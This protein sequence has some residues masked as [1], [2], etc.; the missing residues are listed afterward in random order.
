MNVA[1]ILKIIKWYK[2][3]IYFKTIKILCCK[4]V[5]NAWNIPT[6]TIPILKYN[7]MAL[8]DCH[9]EPENNLITD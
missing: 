5:T 6:V 9:K 2:N 1:D 8:L 7:M 3:C 4:T